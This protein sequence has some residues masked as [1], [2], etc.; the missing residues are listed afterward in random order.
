MNDGIEGFRQLTTWVEVIA[1]VELEG[2]IYYKAP[3]DLMPR[4]IRAERMG[5]EIRVSPLFGK[6]FDSFMA[7]EDHLSRFHAHDQAP[8]SEDAPETLPSTDVTRVE[9][10][11]S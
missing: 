11:R 8:S 7:D 5:N 3:L 10:R 6:D 2:C 1:W 9:A 4:R